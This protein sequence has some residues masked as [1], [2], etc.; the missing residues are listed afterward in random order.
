MENYKN[1]IWKKIVKE[2]EEMMKK[3]ATLVMYTDSEKLFCQNFNYFHKLITDKFMK[4]KNEHLDRHKIAAI[5]ICSI[6]KTDILGYCPMNETEM[7]SGN[8]FLSNEK[9]ALDVAL[10]DMYYSLEQDFSAGEIPYEKIFEDYIFPRPLSCDREYTEVICRDLYYAK[11]FFELDPLS[12]ANFLFFL[13]SYSFEVSGIKINQ[14]KWDELRN[15]RKKNDLKKELAE[16][17]KLL[18]NF[19]KDA[20][21]KKNE[22]I[23]KKN[24]IYQKL[25]SI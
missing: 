22:L 15:S 6:L 25:R 18:E 10:S 23:Q 20:N 9:L 11:K 8:I 3:D 7:F 21:H 24:E 17:E 5:I 2:C 14:E 12:I 1:I 16:T 19:D 4:L 13:E